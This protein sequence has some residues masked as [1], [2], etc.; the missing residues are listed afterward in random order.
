MDKNIFI[1]N[2]QRVG[3][4]ARGSAGYIYDITVTGDFLKFYFASPFSNQK[5]SK[6]PLTE[7]TIL[8]KY[9][10]KWFFFNSDTN[11]MQKNK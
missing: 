4:S 6:Y 11:I 5:P 7:S 9:A 1:C 8:H 3:Q 10:T 2:S